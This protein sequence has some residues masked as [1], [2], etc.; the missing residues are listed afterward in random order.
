MEADAGAPV[1]G[2]RVDGGPTKNVY[3]MQ[4]QS[5]I[6]NGDVLVPQAEE[7]SGIGAAYA[8]GIA[9]G[10]YNMDLF[11][12]MKRKTYFPEMQEEVRERKYQG[13]KEAVGNI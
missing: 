13:W 3:L 1:R 8:A 6:L 2:L 9:M 5:D 11:S 10:I 4:F 12:K 7:L